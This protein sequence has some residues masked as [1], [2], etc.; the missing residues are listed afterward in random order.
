MTEADE[1]ADVIRARRIEL[2]DDAG[3][4]RLIAHHVRQH[5][6]D[7]VVLDLCSPD[8]DAHVTVSCNEHG[9]AVELWENGN[10]VASLRSFRD[11]L[12]V[13]NLSEP[14]LSDD[15]VVLRNRGRGTAE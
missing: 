12:A 14:D 9:A 4:E 5:D 10:S 2:V 8:G 6:Y 7:A 3:V 15:V 13:L 1:T 11:G